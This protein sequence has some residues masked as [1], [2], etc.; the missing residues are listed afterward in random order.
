MGADHQVVIEGHVQ[1]VIL[2]GEIVAFH[3]DHVFCINFADGFGSLAVDGVERVPVVITRVIILVT[4][5]GAGFVHQIVSGQCR[6]ILVPFCHLAPQTDKTVLKEFVLVQQDVDV[7]II[8]VPVG[9]VPTLNGMKIE[10]DVDAVLGAPIHRLVEASKPGLQIFER[11]IIAFEMA[12]VERDAEDVRPELFHC[13]DVFFGEEVVQQAVEEELRLFL[14]EHAAHGGAQVVLCTD[15][16]VDEIL[17]V[18]PAADIPSAQTD[19]LC[20]KR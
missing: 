15:K 11:R 12:V 9:V 2:A 10:D 17:H 8:A 13:P 6:V 14:S 5:T 1:A 20:P 7:G 18:E 16:A 19:G 4:D 3:E